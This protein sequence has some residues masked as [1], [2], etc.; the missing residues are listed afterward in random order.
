MSWQADVS[1]GAPKRH[2]VVRIRPGARTVDRHR[3]PPRRAWRRSAVSRARARLSCARGVLDDRHRGRARELLRDRFRPSH[4]QAEVRHRAT[5]AQA[6]AIESSSRAS[7][8]VTPLVP[9][10]GRTPAASIRRPCSAPRPA[11]VTSRATLAPHSPS[12][13]S[14]ACSRPSSAASSNPAFAR[15]RSQA[16]R[17]MRPRAPTTA[18][19]RGALI[20][21]AAR[22]RWR[23]RWPRSTGTACGSRSRPRRLPSARGSAGSARAACWSRG[24]RAR[25]RRRAR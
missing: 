18:T 17:P 11:T 19:R 3:S 14:S 10:T 1:P 21:C 23:A 2:L 5:R 16:K 20:R 13:V 9:I 8:R 25:R 6:R 22:R 24:T 4:A 12:T 15:R 7:A